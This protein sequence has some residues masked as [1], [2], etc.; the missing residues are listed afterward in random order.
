[1]KGAGGGAL[2]R[3]IEQEEQQI[4]YILQCNV[5]EQNSSLAVNDHVSSPRVL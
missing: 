3:R 4:S 2:G 5:T 1:M